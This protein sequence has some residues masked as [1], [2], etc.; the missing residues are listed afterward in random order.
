MLRKTPEKRASESNWFWPQ[1]CRPAFSP[2]NAVQKEL[3]EGVFLSA[4]CTE[5]M[6][7]TG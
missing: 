6:R 2:R 4:A 7:C 1:R 3:L 5:L